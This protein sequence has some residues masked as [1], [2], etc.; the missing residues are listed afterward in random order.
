MKELES[1]LENMLATVDKVFKV[2]LMKM[3]PPLQ[4]TLL[5]DLISEEEVPASEVSIAM[6]SESREIDQPL[7][8][9]PSRRIKSTDSPP[10][11]VQRS[12]SKALKAGK[13][14][15]KI[16]TLAGS[17]S[18]GNL[19][20][21]SASIRRAQSFLVNRKTAEQ[22]AQNQAKRKLR[23]VMSASDLPCSMAGSA[24]HVTVTTARGEMVS[25][26]EETKDD[27]NWDLLDDVAWC[28][29]QKLTRLME[30]LSQKSRCQR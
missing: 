9:I 14:A 7:R 20:P 19:M 11:E 12:S 30:Y 22:M 25:F 6:K 8:R 16:Q 3:P 15:K 2:E 18:T 4:N 24:A 27:I 28:Q 26:S 5:G 13:R 29:I 21:S 1:K 23:S 10:V 17:N